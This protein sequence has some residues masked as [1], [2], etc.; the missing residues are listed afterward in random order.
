MFQVSY[1]PL[2]ISDHPELAGS[3]DR[4]PEELKRILEIVDQTDSMARGCVWV[5]DGG[6]MPILLYKRAADIARE[7]DIWS[8]GE[9]DNWFTLDI[10]DFGDK[11]VMV[12]MPNLSRS[13]RRIKY[14]HFLQHEEIAAPDDS[15]VLFKPISF[16]SASIGAFEQVRNILPTRMVVGF[17]NI[18]LFDADD[19][20]SIDEDKVNRFGP[21]WVRRNP[22]ETMRIAEDIANQE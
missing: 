22:K 10:I 21:V 6:P 18:D 4:T 5:D 16:L 9:P 12:L 3:T 20:T 8:E 15:Q 14:N 2:L 17:Y 1:V 13:S 19:L 7:L 11:Y